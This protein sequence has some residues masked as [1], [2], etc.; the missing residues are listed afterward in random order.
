MKRIC[1]IMS[2][3]LL[4]FSF[5]F[6]QQLLK[7]DS[8]G[9]KL[10]KLYLNMHIETGWL[11]GQHVDW[12]TGKQDDPNATTENTTHCS[13]FVAAACDRMGIYI[14]RPPEHEQEL[15]ANAQ[16]NWLLSAKGK[17][18]G[19]R[20]LNKT[21]YKTAQQYANQGY[22]V[23]ATYK[24]PNPQRAGHI[25]CVM[26]S[27]IEQD[28]LQQNGPFIIQSSR[29]NNS[30]IKFRTAFHRVIKKQWPAQNVLFFYN[31]KRVK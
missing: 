22:M 21:D 2:F 11:N 9:L 23:V 17:V 24:N 8:L 3:L 1:F 27:E 4:G 16:Y 6:S 25:V 30:N 18:N 29:I 14:L 10:Q 15:L 5:A 7:P 26:P 31:T 20:Q 19:W 28:S 12:R 13:A